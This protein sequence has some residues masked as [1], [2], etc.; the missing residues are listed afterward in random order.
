MHK[1]DKRG[2]GVSDRNALCASVQN[3]SKTP[4]T[5]FRVMKRNS[6]TQAIITIFQTFFAIQ[7][8]L[9]PTK[10]VRI[11]VDGYFLC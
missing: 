8:R 10:K 11:S 3:T 9:Q 1:S 5:V 4:A 2:D 7:K 6:K